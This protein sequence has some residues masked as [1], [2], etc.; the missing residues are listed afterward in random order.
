M[1]A[2]GCTAR[3][4]SAC[5]LLPLSRF[6]PRT[7]GPIP[8]LWREIWALA[9]RAALPL[10]PVFWGVGLTHGRG[11]PVLLIPGFTAGDDSLATMARWLR[12]GGYTP[13]PAGLGP[14][15]GCAGK[16]LD[17]LSE[18][19]E[20]LTDGSGERAAIIGQSRGGC[21]ARA[22]GVRRPELIAGVVAL[23]SP[24][25][26]E[27]ASH[28][29]V[30][31]TARRI[32]ALGDRGVPGLLSSQCADGPCCERYR[33]EL[34][35][36]FPRQVP[37]FSVYSRFDG[38]VDWRSCLDPDAEQVEVMATHNGMNA[39]AGTYWVIARALSG[40]WHDEVDGE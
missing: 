26:D 13:V 28:P 1:P 20:T 30:H 38:V 5:F 12:S 32:A 4:Q 24:L 34:R 29:A 3:S 10:H 19:L 16:L 33:R 14:N 37:F 35:A 27:L 18:R 7:P 9:E 31:A 2:G 22:L 25:L 21:L 36:P 8:P 15:V 39:E 11:R 40:F 17:A 23:G 6:P